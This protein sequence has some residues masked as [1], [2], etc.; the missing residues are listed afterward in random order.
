MQSGRL[1]RSR[2]HDERRRRGGRRGDTRRAAHKAAYEA[3][4]AVKVPSLHKEAPLRD[5]PIIYS[6]TA[7]GGI[8]E[9]KAGG[10]DEVLGRVELGKDH[11]TGEVIAPNDKA[12]EKRAHIAAGVDGAKQRQVD[13][14]AERLKGIRRRA[15][16]RPS[17]DG[18]CRAP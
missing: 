7:P 11:I 17:I 13:A 5:A 16:P 4:S 18:H 8:I 2:V 15:P 3:S 1:A 9:L 14:L 12:E 10:S 6:G